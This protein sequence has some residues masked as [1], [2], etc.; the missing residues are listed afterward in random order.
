M[1]KRKRCRKLCRYG[2][3]GSATVRKFSQP[4]MRRKMFA[5]LL[6]PPVQCSG[7]SRGIVRAPKQCD[8]FSGISS[9][10]N[11]QTLEISLGDQRLRENDNAAA[12][13]WTLADHAHGIE[14]LSCLAVTRQ[15]FGELFLERFRM[16]RQILASLNHPGIA[17]LLDGG[18]GQDGS[19]F[20]AL[21]R[22]VGGFS[23]GMPSES[24]LAGAKL[25]GPLSVNARISG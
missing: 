22:L 7:R 16:E 8:R 9:V 10:L 2:K 23:A 5:D 15:G 21:P 11:Q 25:F 4:L 12:L 20:L 13:W 6:L 19:V 18:V 17:R 1:A 3:N 14:E 24:L